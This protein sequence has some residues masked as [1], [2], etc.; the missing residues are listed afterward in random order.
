MSFLKN[1]ETA[2]GWWRHRGREQYSEQ[3]AHSSVHHSHTYRLKR[4]E[5]TADTLEIFFLPQIWG[6]PMAELMKFQKLLFHI[7]LVTS[8]AHI[9]VHLPKSITEQYEKQHLGPKY[10]FSVFRI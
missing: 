2:S 9:I 5:A 6:S 4:A 3:H 7:L 1:Y 8:Q 10:L